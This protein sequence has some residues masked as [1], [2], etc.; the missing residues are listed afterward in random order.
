ML[1]SGFTSKSDF[2]DLRRSFDFFLVG[3][4]WS[5]N[6]FGIRNL[7][8]IFNLCPIDLPLNGI[9]IESNL[10]LTRASFLMLVSVI[11]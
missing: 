11:R 8:R 4:C 5:F 3:L 2:Q 1:W 6:C 10:C 9:W 7:L